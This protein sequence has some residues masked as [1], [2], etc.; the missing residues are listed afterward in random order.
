MNKQVVLILSLVASSLNPFAAYAADTAELQVK[1]VIRPTACTPS[2]AGDGVVDFGTIPASSLKAGVY[3]RLPPK[4]LTLSISC[5]SP[6]K[7]AFTVTDNRGSSRVAGIPTDSSYPTDEGQ[8]FGL[9]AVG[10]KN[11]GG[12]VLA[13]TQITMDGKTASR[14]YSTDSGNTWGL[15]PL[16]YVE[17][18]QVLSFAADGTMT[19]AAFSV[20]TT[21]IGVY[22][23]LNKP[24]NL[25]LTSDVPLDGSATIELRYL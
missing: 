21:T 23:G 9:G 15:S 14:I 18:Y 8:N 2:L 13:T 11:V 22:V 4:E 7:M 24:E 12:Y 16:K 20:L 17:R 1:G 25:T 19:P 10:G 6:G 3:T 5:A